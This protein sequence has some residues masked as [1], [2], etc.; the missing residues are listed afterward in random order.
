MA[1]GTPVEDRLLTPDLHLGDE[2]AVLR[3]YVQ[4]LE[5]YIGR[6]VQSTRRR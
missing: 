4:P 2:R 6:S 5:G 1:S 3:V